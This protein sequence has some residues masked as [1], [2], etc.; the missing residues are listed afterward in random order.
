VRFRPPDPPG[1]LRRAGLHLVGLSA[2]AVAQPL[3]DLLGRNAEF[4][5]VRGSSRWEIVCFA[6]ALVALPPLAIL[7]LETLAGLAHAAAATAVHLVGVAGLVGLL[8]LQAVR[9]PEAPAA[10]L[11]A[12]TAGALSAL[13]YARTRPARMLLT[14]LGAAPLLF[15]G[16]F[17]L[18]SPVSK[19]VLARPPEPALA[20]VGSDAPVVMVVLDELPIISLLDADGQIDAVRYPSFARLAADA[21]WYRNATTVH[22]WTTS[23]V[24]AVL[25]GRMPRDGELP[26]YLDHPDNLFTL[27]GGGYDLRVT[28]S[29]THLCPEELCA[30]ERESLVERVGSLLSDLIVVYGHL[31]L[32]EE[33]TD[34]LPSISSAWEDFGGDGGP[35]VRLQ[36]GPPDPSA[37]FPA[38]AERDAKVADFVDSLARSER[39]TLSFLHVLLPHHP[40]EYLPNGK[41]YAADLGFQPGMVGERWVGDPELAVQAQQRHLL[42]TG[43]VDL[44]LGRILDR[45]EETGQYERALVVVLADHGV[46]FRPHDERRRVHAGNVGEIA[47]VPLFV[48]APGQRAGRVVDDHVR[49]T[50]VLPTMAEHL[51]V[52]LPWETDGRSVAGRGAWPDRHVVVHTSSGEVVSVPV[53]AALAARGRALERQL[54]LFGSG[55][56][57]PGLFGIGPRPELIGRLVDRQT[58]AAPEGRSFESFG[59][60]RYDPTAGFAPVRVYGR[61]RGVPAGADVAIALRGRVVAVTRSFAHA[62]RTLLSAVVPEDALRPGDNAIRAYLVDGPR[63]RPLLREI[64]PRG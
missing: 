55:S 45:L 29:Q 51:G 22:E 27:L 64:P 24:P 15:V 56:E 61:L 46:S 3:F 19:L 43:Y 5:A 32:P 39:P 31:A 28:E 50:D 36:E 48:K 58:V 49:T 40:W 41:L 60:G 18:A 16:L 13:L 20:H 52:E 47:F 26:L 10:L 53:A 8:T 12:A 17:L 44:V 59:V 25:T 37:R 7:A 1:S 62:G 63:E 33:L 42:Q 34:R 35:V 30:A 23:A 2:L 57:P 14:V 38:Y 9:G 21:A 54:E 11:A 4:F 6:V